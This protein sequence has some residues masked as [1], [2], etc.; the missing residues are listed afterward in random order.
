MIAVGVLGTPFIGA[1][2][3]QTAVADLRAS[4]PTVAAQVIEEK[5]AL[6]LPYEAVSPEKAAA[7]SD[8]AGKDAI[9]AAKKDGQFDALAKMALFPTFML[10]CY[11][12]LFVYFKT[13]GGYKAQDI[14][15]GGGH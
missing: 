2:Q 14:T 1:I 12:I 8:Q 3:E 9:A 5:K 6:G 7:V 4:N 11:I 15:H 10:I 13:R